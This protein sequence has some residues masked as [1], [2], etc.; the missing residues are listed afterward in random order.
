VTASVAGALLLVLIG[1]AFLCAATVGWW[2]LG[3]DPSSWVL[4]VTGVVIDVLVGL[5]ALADGF[6]SVIGEPERV[7]VWSVGSAVLVV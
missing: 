6:V 4:R 2:R 3:E 5:V 1:V 7:V